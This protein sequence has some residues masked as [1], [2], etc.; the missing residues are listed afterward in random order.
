VT[1]HIPSFRSRSCSSSSLFAS[2]TV[3]GEEGDEGDEE[4]DSDE[5]NEEEIPRLI[6]AEI[7]STSTATSPR[8]EVTRV[9]T[10][11]EWDKLKKIQE[12]LKS[13][14]KKRKMDFDPSVSGDDLEP[15]AKKSRTTYEERVAAKLL[16]KEDLSEF[17]K[18]G[19]KRKAQSTSNVS[20]KKTK[21]FVML[22]QKAL[23]K[24]RRTKKQKSEIKTAHLKKQ[25][26]M[27]LN[28]KF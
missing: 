1:S 16:N 20:K 13:S 6:P 18:F 10:D 14:N 28:K 7:S 15:A 22:R 2:E 26:R 25:R 23:K 12:K 21:N 8:A 3:S 4:G 27:K 9:F 24:Q 5:G 17:R 11:E 19:R